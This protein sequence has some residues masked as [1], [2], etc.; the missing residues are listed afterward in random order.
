MRK[1]WWVVVGAALTGMTLTGCELGMPGQPRHE[2]VSRLDAVDV[3]VDVAADGSAAVRMEVRFVDAVGG[4]V[5]LVM[6]NRPGVTSPIVDLAVDGQPARPEAGTFD[7]VVRVGTASAVVTYR[8]APAALVGSDVGV[9]DLVVVPQPGDNSRQDPPAAVTATIAFPTPLP[10]ATR[11]V[12]LLGRDRTTE[13]V[14]N[15]VVFTA[16]APVW[17]PANDIVIVTDP[18]MYPA[19]VERSFDTRAAVD[20]LLTSRM[21]T[22]AETEVTLGSLD[23]Q[24]RV[25]SGVLWAAMI[26]PGAFCW[27]MLVLKSLKRAATNR[28]E[29][30]DVA[31]ELREPPGNDDPAVVGVLIGDRHPPRSTVAGSLLMLAHRRVIEIQEAGGGTD[32][33]VI[34]RRHRGNAEGTERLIAR[35]LG[36]TAN[37]TEARSPL[38]WPARFWRR[39]RRVAIGLARRQGL[40]ER[41]LPATWLMAAITYSSVGLGV[42]LSGGFGP[43]VMLATVLGG[44]FLGWSLLFLTGWQL[45]R[46]GRRRRAEW[47]AYQ[48]FLHAADNL[49]EVGPGAVAIWGPHLA[50]AAVL[51]AAPRAA[52]LLTP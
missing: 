50:Y 41:R 42:G 38:A 17:S 28:W 44:C 14:G 37:R 9:L 24:E 47:Q 3:R 11:A 35:A 46:A 6:P 21:T 51:D 32:D 48:R 33:F 36:L 45:S 25:A 8:L 19:M 15:T 2:R 16:S 1:G 30:R 39:Y 4:T 12:N 22:A 26:V 52:R 23:T 20:A 31:H 43:F 29:V 5:G 18:S 40:V 34:R 27:L 10:P 13:V 49:R 7:P